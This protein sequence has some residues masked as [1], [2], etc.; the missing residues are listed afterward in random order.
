MS[1]ITEDG[2]ASPYRRVAHALSAH[3]DRTAAGLIALLVV[4][5]L[6]PALVGGGLL[7]PT[8]L[9]HV[10]PP[11]NSVAPPPGITHYLNGDLGDVPFTYYVWN[12][13]AREII[14][15]GTFPAWNPFALGGT[16]LF[17]NGQ[18]AWLS[19]FSLPLWILPLNYGLGVAA[20]LKLW[21]A[22]FGTYLLARA[23]RLAFWPAMLAGVSFA[24]CAFNVLWLS[25]GVFVS[26]AVLMPWALW[27]AERL[28]Q[29]GRSVDALAL[30]AILAIALTGGH[31][32]TQLHVLAGTALYALARSTTIAESTRREQ[33]RRI[34]SVGG[35]FLLA[36]LIAAVVLLPAIE[37]SSDTVGAL[38]RMHGAPT[39]RSSRMPVEVVRSTLFPEWWGRP[40][41]QFTIEGPASYKERTFYAGVAALLFAL[42][43]VCSAGE[44]RR[45]AP[46]ALLGALG[47]AISLR[48]PGIYEFIIELPGFDRVQNG[49]IVLWFLLAVALLAGFGLQHVSEARHRLGSAWTAPL[50]LLLAAVVAFVSLDLGD[51]HWRKAISHMLHRSDTTDRTTLALASVLWCA[52]WVAALLVVVVLARRRSWTSRA[53]GGLIVLV[54][55]LDLLH[56]AIGFQPI[57]PSEKIVPPPTPAIA[58]LQRH[59]EDR[60]AGV[61]VAEAD[62]FTLYGLH[63]V[64]GRDEPLPTLRYYRMWN[65]VQPN[66]TAWQLSDLAQSGP[67]ILGLLGV[68]YVMTPPRYGLT[69]SA[70]KP[71]YSGKDATIYANALASPR[72]TVATRGVSIAHDE[73]AEFMALEDETFDA[74]RDAVV[75][76]DELDGLRLP[77]RGSGTVQVVDRQN[78]SV[79]LRATLSRPSL[80]VLHE[81]W[82]DG[83]TVEIDG[84]PARALQTDVVLRGVI[85]PAGTH[86][87]VWRYRVRGLR[88]GL[89]LTTI[90]LLAAAAWGGVLVLRG[91]RERQRDPI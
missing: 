37:A 39:F 30:A 50:A 70:L 87:V 66:V 19:P 81:T 60:I 21:A 86:E 56:F 4:V 38:V 13:I 23:H 85:V 77:R 48:A 49:R 10:Y 34:A 65:L 26:V 1:A 41:E 63:D 17:A 80:V 6:W 8:G 9:L 74:R 76:A 73:N 68:R 84:R 18:I 82:D 35:A 51:G 27:L 46:F 33:A 91:R 45:K 42:V 57:G 79:A 40:S 32:G 78:A 11:W 67:R 71:V 12:A 89:A 25:Y 75:R 55:A 14:H 22:G 90:G 29:R 69:A 83:W 5:Y 28:I 3:P 62:W 15:S 53:A 64:R 36:A 16:P 24:L 20:A 58:F 2:T 47:L 72:A 44:W 7:A 43:A 59:P 61:G 88:A 31:P 54:A 52:L